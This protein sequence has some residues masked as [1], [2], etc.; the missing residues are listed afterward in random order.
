MVSRAGCLVVHTHESGTFYLSTSAFGGSESQLVL[1]QVLD[2]LHLGVSPHTLQILKIMGFRD[3]WASKA[4]LDESQSATLEFRHS[5]GAHI[6]S[7]LQFKATS[8]DLKAGYGA[9]P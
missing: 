3:L 6:R 5:L 9:N 7:H 2:S 8:S 4:I 1:A